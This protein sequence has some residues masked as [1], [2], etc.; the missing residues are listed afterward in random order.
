M[1]QLK[2]C[3]MSTCLHWT[4]G[5]VQRL[6]GLCWTHEKRRRVS[7]NTCMLCDGRASG[8]HRGCKQ[9]GTACAC[10][11][12]C[13]GGTGGNTCASCTGGTLALHAPTNAPVCALGNLVKHPPAKKPKTSSKPR[14]ICSCCLNP[15]VTGFLTHAEVCPF[16]CITAPFHF[17]HVFKAI[18]SHR[19]KGL[20]PQLDCVYPPVPAKFNLHYVGFCSIGRRKD[21]FQT[22]FCT[23]L[24]LSLESAWT[25]STWSAK[26][27]P[28]F[29]RARRSSRMFTVG[30]A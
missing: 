24:G 26:T 19:Q 18:K 15:V 28:M 9:T 7:W 29:G 17:E 30:A 1:P 22:G 8:Q 4:S 13:I 21:S 14:R 10:G 2:L 27:R 3:T 12:S 16:A 23:C 20:R 5:R 11:P 6:R 25:L